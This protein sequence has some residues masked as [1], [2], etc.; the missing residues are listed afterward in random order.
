MLNPKSPLSTKLRVKPIAFTLFH[1]NAYQGPCRYGEGYAL[2]YEYDEE[3]GHRQLEDFRK[4]LTEAVDPDKVELLEPVMLH[5]CEDF[6]MSEELFAEALKDD[7]SVDFYLIYALRIS[8]LFIVR[9]AQRTEK[10]IGIISSSKSISRVGDVDSAARL[11]AMGKTCYSFFSY[12]DI[13][14][15]VDALRIKK[16]L[17]ETRI[18][19]PLKGDSLSAGCQSSFMTLDDV[20]AKFGVRF[21][22]MDAMELL[23]M[24]DE[25]TED[26]KEKV[27]AR[28]NLVISNAVGTHMPTE[29]I[30]N[31]VGFYTVVQKLLDQYDCNAFTILCF[32]ICATMELMKRKTMFCLTH[33]LLRDEGI[34]SACAGD[35]GSLIAME[36]L[37]DMSKKSPYMGNTMVM[38][39]ENNIVRTLHDVPSRHMKGYDTDLPVEL[40]SF[41]LSNWGTTMRYNFDLD[42]GEKITA[43]GMSPDFKKMMIVSGTIEGCDNYL[44]PECSLAMRY[45]VADARR[46]Y[47]YQQYIGH[48]FVVVYG[49]YA[50]RLRKLAGEYGME[51]LVL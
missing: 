5:W 34:P 23:T 38:D 26:E 25:L 46:F 11:H 47:E 32:E 7:D 36:M 1:R 13:M 37:M 21:Q 35:V 3:V 15:V 51:T 41:T 30:I 16:T 44:V 49:D 10:P 8:N 6:V 9:L 39:M 2:T 43:M 14:P 17:S 48:H 19:Y 33:S 22:H 42:K 27:R 31:D 24:I 12:A 40:V 29:N 4:Q 18:L 28:A 50:D 20:S 45:Q